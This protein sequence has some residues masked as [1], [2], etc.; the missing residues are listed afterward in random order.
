MSVAK[1]FDGA[2]SIPNGDDVAAE[3]FLRCHLNSGNVAVSDSSDEE[4]G[5]LGRRVEAADE[6]ATIE[7]LVPN[8][9]YQFTAGGAIAAGADFF[10]AN[11]GKVSATDNGDR[12]GVALTPASGDGSAFRGIYKGAEVP[13]AS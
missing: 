4:D 11:G 5:L 7:P 13:T 3:P 1:V 12:L 6:M 2:Y 8:C 9:V 10:R